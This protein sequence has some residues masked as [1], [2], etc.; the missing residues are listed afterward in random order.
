MSSILIIDD[1]RA[2]RKTLGEILSYEGYKIE[3]VC[4]PE[5]YARDP[6][7]V[8]DFYNMRRRQ[9]NAAQ[10]N[11]A[12]KALVALEAAEMAVGMDLAAPEAQEPLTSAVVAAAA[13]HSNARARAAAP[14]SASSA[15]ND[16]K[17]VIVWMNR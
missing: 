16:H 5:A 13:A 2:I 11:A 17:E 6:K 1:E 8:L 4:T 12:H 14:E 15:T 3:E 10:P 7:K 9:A